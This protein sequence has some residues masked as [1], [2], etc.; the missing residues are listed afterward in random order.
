MAIKTVGFGPTL[1]VHW[2]S[3]MHSFEWS[4]GVL[5]VKVAREISS[6]R[7]FSMLAEFAIEVRGGDNWVS[8]SYPPTIMSILKDSSR[9]ARIDLNVI[10]KLGSY[11]AVALYEICARYRDNPSGVTSRKPVSWWSDALSQL[12]GAAERREWRKFRS[13]RLLIAIKEINR[14]TDFEIEL[15]EHKEGRAVSEV[16]FGVRRRSRWPGA[17]PG[18]SFPPTPIWCCGR[19]PSPYGN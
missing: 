9:W 7:A 13:E 10:A 4:E 2:G 11:T 6:D 3:A 15:I 19:N 16:Q 12:P 17:S 18:R 14:E 5:T 1:Q 8:W